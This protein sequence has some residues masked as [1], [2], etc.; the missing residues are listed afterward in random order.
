LADRVSAVTLGLSDINGPRGGADLRCVATVDLVQNGSV[1]AAAKD[2]D[3][4]SACRTRAP[5]P[6]RAGPSKASRSGNVGWRGGV[7][8]RALAR[9]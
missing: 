3:L 2:S 1:R 7:S 6:A 5:W 4:L 8:R 9:R